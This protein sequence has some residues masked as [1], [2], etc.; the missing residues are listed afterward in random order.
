[1]KKI[2]I[3][4]SVGL[5][6]LAGCGSKGSKEK[7][8]EKTYSIG[9]V[10]Q[11]DYSSSTEEGVSK[12]EANVT[13]TTVVLEGDK[14]AYLVIDTAQNDVKMEKQSV[15]KLKELKKNV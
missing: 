5:L 6:V 7:I 3:L 1:M 2:L 12:F 10:I 9:T 13:Y 8:E 15:L 14:I 4:L 11:N